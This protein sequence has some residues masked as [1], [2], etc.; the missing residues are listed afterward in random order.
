M[1]PE[2][3]I[4]NVARE[5][6]KNPKKFIIAGN[7]GPYHDPETNLRVYGHWLI[8]FSFCYKLTKNIS[9]I[10][11]VNELAENMISSKYRPKNASF[12]HRNK[13]GTDRCNGL[14]GQAWTFE[15][16]SEASN[17]L[18]NN[19]YVKIAREVFFKHKFNENFG[20][21]HSLEING[22]ILSI[23]DTFNHQL[24]FA[25]CSLLLSNSENDIIFKRINRFIECLPE[26]I[27]MLPNGL[28]LHRVKR[29]LEFLN[30]FKIKNLKK[31]I[32]TSF[33][34]TKEIFELLN[35]GRVS[36]YDKMIKK[37]IG[38]HC[39]NMF[40]FAMLK[41]KIPNHSIWRSEIINDSVEYLKV[42]DYFNEL[43]DNIFSYPYNPPGF[44]VPYSLMILGGEKDKN[45]C[46]EPWLSTQIKKTYSIKTS[47][48]QKNNEDPLTLTS[49]IYE[50]TRYVSY[51]SK[52]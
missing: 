48:F 4:L 3:L 9:F 45:K 39:F 19:I 30:G 12:H 28:I 35:K 22:K 11:K 21:W 43:E 33:T 38:Y 20:L 5:A 23:D 42:K 17:I 15:A 26:N 41:T 24:W 34:K 51:L 8:T 40:A 25:A 16:L 47:F 10:N 32:R 18:N 37:S 14:I 29:N 52:L 7:N 44:E 1:E 46:I 49:R 13:A 36:N 2:S 27:D 6:L 50:L 31:L